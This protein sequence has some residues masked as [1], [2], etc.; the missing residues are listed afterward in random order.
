ME[1]FAEAFFK[2]PEKFLGQAFFL[3]KAGMEVFWTSLFF[4][5]G[6]AEAFFK[7]PEGGAG[8]KGDFVKE[9]FSEIK[10]RENHKAKT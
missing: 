3:K 8:N 4:K 10:G 6:G 5:K 2:K 7:K 1:V 9:K